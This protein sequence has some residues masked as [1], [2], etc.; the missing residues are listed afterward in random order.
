M[1][2]LMT[3]IVNAHSIE[4]QWSHLK[5]VTATV[6]ALTQSGSWGLPILPNFKAAAKSIFAPCL[7]TVSSRIHIH[8][9]CQKPTKTN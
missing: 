9:Y 6:A 7:H 2:V 1:C 8:Q 5:V 4:R 3:I